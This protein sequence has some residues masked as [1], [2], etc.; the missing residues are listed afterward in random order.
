[1]GSSPDA[2]VYA[3]LLFEMLL[4]GQAAY[5]IPRIDA[6]QKEITRSRLEVLNEANKRRT[7][8]AL[9]RTRCLTHNNNMQL[10]CHSIVPGLPSTSQKEFALQSE[11]LR[12]VG[13][14]GLR[15]LRQFSAVSGGT[16]GSI[17][18]GIRWV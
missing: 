11:W 12:P 3:W 10:K 13:V 16:A 15:R 6:T 9:V 7:V 14:I 4:M 1:M 8:P 2:S 5:R 18:P 17:L